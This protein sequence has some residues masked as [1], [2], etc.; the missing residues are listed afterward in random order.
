MGIGLQDILANTTG[1]GANT[2]NQRR[3]AAQGLTASAG[4]MPQM[5]WQAIERAAAEARYRGR[6]TDSPRV[7]RGPRS[8]EDPEQAPL[9]AQDCSGPGEKPSR[10]VLCKPGRVAGGTPRKQAPAGKEGNRTEGRRGGRGS[11]S[12]EGGDNSHD[13]C[14]SPRGPSGP[15]RCARG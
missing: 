1:D 3:P 8:T 2:R 13:K 6:S 11:A 10:A 15:W 9:P 4:E 14:Q 12:A 5:P 7:H